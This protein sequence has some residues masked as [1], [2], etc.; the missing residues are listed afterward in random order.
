MTG[1]ELTA[2]T[3]LSLPSSGTTSLYHY[4]QPQVHLQI[5]LELLSLLDDSG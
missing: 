1:F 3:C 5:C 4:A 2:L